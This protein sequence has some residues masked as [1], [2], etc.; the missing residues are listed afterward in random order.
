M[1]CDK[2][3][4]SASY[5]GDELRTP[6]YSGLFP[7]FFATSQGGQGRE[8]KTGANQKSATAPV[9]VE[10]WAGVSVASGLSAAHPTLGGRPMP[11]V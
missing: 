9:A 2:A 10:R 5:Y 6:V 4:S 3:V 1:S 11:R 8:G 7:L